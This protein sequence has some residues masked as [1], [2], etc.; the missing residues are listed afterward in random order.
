MLIKPRVLLLFKIQADLDVHLQMPINILNN[1][2][3]KPLASVDLSHATTLDPQ[4]SSTTKK[5][6]YHQLSS[7]ERSEFLIDTSQKKSLR[8]CPCVRQILV[9][10]WKTLILVLVW[11]TN[12]VPATYV[13][14]IS[15]QTTVWYQVRAYNIGLH[16][17]LEKKTPGTSERFVANCGV[18]PSTRGQ[19]DSASLVKP[20]QDQRR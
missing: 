11:G 6:S 9:L 3:W 1:D 5:V 17:P 15:R 20:T 14:G 2:L 19:G 4:L 13:P 7:F 18:G 8:V 12:Y 10:V 16:P